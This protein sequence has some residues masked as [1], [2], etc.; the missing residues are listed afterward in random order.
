MS[1]K[2]HMEVKYGVMVQMLGEY[3]RVK[4]LEFFL[5]NDDFDASKSYVAKETE[6]SR[7]TLEPIWNE[8]EEEGIIVKTR[9]IGR[10][11]M[12]KLDKNNRTA[13]VLQNF[14]D[15]LASMRADEEEAKMKQKVLA[16]KARK[17]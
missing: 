4:V 5:I 15:S 6:V 10:A 2:T 1:K 14:L 7:T 8:L 3:P 9:T 16:R 13:Q 11:E 12:F 17:R